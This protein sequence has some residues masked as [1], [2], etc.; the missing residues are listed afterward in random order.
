MSD[1]FATLL[2]SIPNLQRHV[3]L[4]PLTYIKVGGPAAFFAQVATQDE[5]AHAVRAALEADIPFRIIGGGANMLIADAGFDGLIIRNIG[6]ALA[7]DGRRVTVASGYNL[8]K[9]AGEMA[10][11]GFSGLEFAFGI[12]GTVGGAIYGNAGAFSG[13]LQDVVRDVT[14]LR[15]DGTI[16]TVES[17]AL[18]FA[19]RH[20]ALKDHYAVVLSATLE[21]QPGDA[22]QIRQKH[23][24]WLAYRKEHQ[25][26]EFPSLG[27]VFKNVPLAEIGAQL[28]ERFGV[29]EGQQFVAAGLINDRAGLRGLRV[30]DAELSVKHGN[31][32]V[33]RGAA[34]AA[35]VLALIGAIKRRVQELYGG[36]ILR[37]EIEMLGF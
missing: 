36:L 12:P 15:L 5:L 28:R 26:L 9:L 29:Q 14:L 32:I 8:T 6:S 22:D 19:Y 3:P 16:I 34:R 13:S 35:D 20:S 30:G 31:F 10:R 18:Q 23:H 17:A 33:N 11:R 37:E 24:A 25:P 2:T 27:S 4:A 1:I 21:L 7:V